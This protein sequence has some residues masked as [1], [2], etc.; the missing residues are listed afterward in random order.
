M[1]FAATRTVHLERAN[2]TWRLPVPLTPVIDGRELAEGVS[3]LKEASDK[4]KGCQYFDKMEEDNYQALDVSVAISLPWRST[5][6][7]L[8][9]LAD[10]TCDAGRS[11]C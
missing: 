2:L 1:P 7:A 10:L 11:Q 9:S 8:H 4:L 6:H 3:K 5:L